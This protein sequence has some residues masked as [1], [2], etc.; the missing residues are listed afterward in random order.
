MSEG[1]VVQAGSPKELFERPNTT[2]VG[3]FIGSPAMNLFDSE[4]ISSNEVNIGSIKIK[5]NTDLSK[6]KNK[7]VKL[8][9]RSEFLILQIKR[10]TIL[11][12]LRST[13]LKILVILSYLHL[14]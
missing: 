5:T 10:V 14:L 9:I 3:Y 11:L 8:G 13:E 7:H 2:F 4:I 6:V 1:E 12:K